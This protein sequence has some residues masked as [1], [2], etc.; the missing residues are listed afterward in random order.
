MTAATD[1]KGMIIITGSANPSDRCRP[2][3][4]LQAVR[5]AGLAMRRYI[6]AIL[7]AVIPVTGDMDMTI[8]TA[9]PI[10]L[11]PRTENALAGGIKL[12]MVAGDSLVAH[13][14]H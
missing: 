13:L 8:V 7:H 11:I 2:L 9:C 3:P 12:G 14:P 6:K 5:T 4:N 1:I 10:P